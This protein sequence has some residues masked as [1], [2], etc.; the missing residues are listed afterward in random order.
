MGEER[1]VKSFLENGKGEVVSLSLSGTY[2]GRLVSGVD[3]LLVHFRDP[4]RSDG[5]AWPSFSACKQHAQ[6]PRAK[7]GG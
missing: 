1:E 7:P 4:L 6:Y 5:T 2:F 3:H